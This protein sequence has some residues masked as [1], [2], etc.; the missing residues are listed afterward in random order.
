MG[1]T[2]PLS[3]DVRCNRPP[4]S[5]NDVLWIGPRRWQAEVRELRQP[6]CHLL[7]SGDL[8]GTTRMV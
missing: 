3:W 7:C 5:S 1:D 2:D 4:L 8:P 6:R